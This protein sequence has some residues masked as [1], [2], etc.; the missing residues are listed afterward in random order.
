LSRSKWKLKG[1]FEEETVSLS[2]HD[3]K[4]SRIKEQQPKY[5]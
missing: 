2:Y 3:M 5:F 4:Q 1:V